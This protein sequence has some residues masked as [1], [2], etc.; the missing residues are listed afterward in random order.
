MT[1]IDLATKTWKNNLT[2]RG[3]H[4]EF[5]DDSTVWFSNGFK[6]SCFH[7]LA[8]NYV[9]S[10]T[11]KNDLLIFLLSTWHKQ[12]FWINNVR[13]NHLREKPTL[14]PEV[15]FSRW[16]DR[17]ER[18]SRDG[19]SRGGEKKTLSSISTTYSSDVPCHSRARRPLASRV[20]KTYFLTLKTRVENSKRDW[21]A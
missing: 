1:S 5:P 2:W 6:K 10:C 15:F 14:V 16:S 11:K 4:I 21:S 13:V 17:I 3:R 18:Q 7:S 20:V 9:L 19:E 8:K 12:K